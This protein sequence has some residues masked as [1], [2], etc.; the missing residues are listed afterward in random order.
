MPWTQPIAAAPYY[1]QAVITTSE[2]AAPPEAGVP[3]ADVLAISTRVIEARM[4]QQ[5][6]AYARSTALFVEAAKI[7]DRLLYR[8]SPFSHYPRHQSLGAA[9]LA[10]D[11]PQEAEAAFRRALQRSHSNR[12][13]EL[14]SAAEARADVGN[15]RGGTRTPEQKLVRRGNAGA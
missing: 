7:Q 14:L 8:E 6:G 4:A 5:A 12:W 9:L 1:A 13:A 2:I 10:Q 11:M 3:R 15:D